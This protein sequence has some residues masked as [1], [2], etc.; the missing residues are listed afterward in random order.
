MAD[1]VIQVI[2]ESIGE[3]IYTL[4][5]KGT[6]FS[7]KI[8]KQGTYTVKVGEPYTVKIK[9]LKGLQP[10]ESGKKKIIQVTF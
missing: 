6:S 4:R 9:T 7:P 2:D 10:T 1:P 5:I 3:I 8:F